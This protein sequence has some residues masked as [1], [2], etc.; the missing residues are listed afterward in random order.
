MHDSFI[1]FTYTEY[2]KQRALFDSNVAEYGTFCHPLINIH[3][4]YVTCVTLQDVM[5]NEQNRNEGLVQ[6]E[7]T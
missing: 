6:L 4:R 5:W 3:I 2:L 7:A 1:E